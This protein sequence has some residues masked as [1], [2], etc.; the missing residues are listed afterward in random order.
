VT[1]VASALDKNDGP[2]IVT[3]VPAPGSVFP[4]G[5]TNVTCSATDGSGNSASASFPVLVR[6]TRP[7]VLTLPADMVVEANAPGGA[8]ASFVAVATDVADGSIPVTCAPVSG[9]FFAVGKTTVNC[10]ATDSSGNTRN[11]SFNVNVKDTTAP[12]IVSA[13]PSLLILTPPDGRMVTVAIATV[14]TDV[15]DPAPACTITKVTSNEA[16]GATSPDWTITGALTVDL[17]AETKAKKDR[18]YT[19]IVSCSDSSGNT[20]VAKPQITV[21]HAP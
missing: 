21:P 13:V 12:R 15:A 4:R 20:A 3:C 16:L 9:S 17:R 6:D 7:P 8:A 18:I 11:G 10:Q 14:V 19:V 1:F 2:L 5:T